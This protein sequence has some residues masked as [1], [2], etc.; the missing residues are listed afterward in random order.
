MTLQIL[1]SLIQKEPM[2]K[3]FDDRQNTASKNQ[4]HFHALKLVQTISEKSNFKNLAAGIILKWS[5]QIKK[6]IT[7]THI[8][9]KSEILI[10]REWFSNMKKRSNR[11]KFRNYIMHAVRANWG[12]FQHCRSTSSQL[13]SI[14]ARKS[15]ESGLA[16]I[17]RLHYQNNS[18]N[19]KIEP[20]CFENVWLIGKLFHPI[21]IGIELKKNQNPSSPSLGNQIQ[22]WEYKFR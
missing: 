6:W 1:E 14:G 3:G 18:T 2:Q 11:I 21:I 4:K 8:D 5:F 17:C 7:S 16:T 15:K 10:H 12:S 22:K 20:K 13:R 19:W 9:L